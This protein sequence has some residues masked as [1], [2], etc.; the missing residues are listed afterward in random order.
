MYLV[1]LITL[2]VFL[3]IVIIANVI[4]FP[5]SAGDI[6]PGLQAI[7]S[8][9]NQL[10]SRSQKEYPFVAAIVEPRKDNLVKII[11][12]FLRVL[13]A[14][15]HFQVYH[16]TENVDILYI[17]F[18]EEINSG[19]MS[20]WN[21]GIDNL[22]IQGYSAL[23]TSET[24][25]NTIQSER[26]L[27]FQTDAITCDS[28]V[29]IQEFKEYDYV[30][31]PLSMFICVLV[32]L[33]FICKG[34]FL[35]H[36]RYY[37]GGLSYRRKSTALKVIKRYPWDRKCTEDVWFCAFIPHV[38]GKLPSREIARKFSFEAENLSGTPWGLHKPRKDYDQ[39]CNICPNTREIPFIPSHTD[40]RNLYLL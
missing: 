13:P 24:F 30:G 27:I 23:L 6:T 10:E 29:D 5:L 19:K 32:N 11:Q 14:N 15:T 16:G 34:Y 31:A 40:Y 39:L 33:L 3:A 2:L 7:A 4:V 12:H 20:L 9:Q 36:S 17:N 1:I 8:L 26:V 25:W 21:M 35:Q 38:G 18:S 22:S 28:G 37:N